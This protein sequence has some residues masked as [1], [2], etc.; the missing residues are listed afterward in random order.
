MH[1]M[2]KVRKVLELD[3]EE[4]ALWSKIA[5]AEPRESMR[6]LMQAM[7]ENQKKIG[8]SSANFSV[9]TVIWTPRIR[10]PRGA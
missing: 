1:W 5:A 9:S 7:M 3:E 4:L 10:E 8:K 2:E 6:N